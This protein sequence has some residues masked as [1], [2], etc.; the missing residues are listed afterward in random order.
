MPK[1]IISYGLKDQEIHKKEIHVA[2]FTDAFEEAQ[3]AALE[4]LD[5][6]GLLSDF[7]DLVFKQHSDI[8]MANMNYMNVAQDY[9]YFD[10]EDVVEKNQE[11]IMYLVSNQ[12]RLFDDTLFEVITMD[13]AIELMEYE[14]ELALDTETTGLDPHGN[15]LLLIQIGNYDYQ[16]QFDIQSEDGTIPKKLKNFLNTYKG[17]FILQNAKFD[18]QFLLKQDVLIK[19]V[20]DTM[21][22]EIIITN[23]LQISGRDLAT[24]GDKYC[25]V[26]LDKSVR[27]EILFKGLTN[28]VLEYGAND[29]KYLPMIKE[30]QMEIVEKYRLQT[31]VNLD[32]SFVVVLAYTE[33]HGIKLDYD[34]WKK[35]TDKEVNIVQD[36]REDLERTLYYDG[37]KQFFSGMFDMFTGIEDCIVNWN[38]PKQIVGVMES[39]G[40][41]LSIY[42]GGV[43]KKTT[44]AKH[45]EKF[46][47]E[48]PIIPPYLK[49][50]QAQKNLSTYGYNWR[51]LINPHTGRI[52]SSFNQIMI[53]GRLS[54]TEPNM[55]NLPATQE[56][57]ECF[58]A[59]KG[60][61]F[62]VADYSGQEQII[63]A[64]F[65][66]EENLLN[67]YKK[68]F[69]DM[70]SYIA[71]LMYP[72]IRPTT[73][74]ELTPEGLGI[75]K[76]KHKKERQIAKSA[77]FAI[78]PF[79]F[80]F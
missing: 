80:N 58:V 22:V 57:R 30:K 9:I 29:V 64:N 12:A 33:F 49:Y 61:T 38:S 51:Y 10:V 46:K 25:G 70:H 23:G 35:K 20:Y 14:K 40:V 66:K 67:F 13:K 45:I 5:D 39:Y 27:G 53:T 15:K 3:S 21:L 56:T 4:V 78:T 60:N 48:F 2:T 24:L 50:K 41:D 7:K 55:Q 74:E 75:I 63:L 59:E 8:F 28:R 34:K 26:Q 79:T 19:S 36:L 32:N 47:N 17:Q 77:G 37:K 52:H 16:I 6:S 62:I 76:S 54:S 18:I 1:F 31:A 69:T 71:F 43:K 65:S 68:G 42:V 44:N 11:S 73:L 72:D